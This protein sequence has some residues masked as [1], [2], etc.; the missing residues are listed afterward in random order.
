MEA[1]TTSRPEGFSEGIRMSAQSSNNAVSESV[2]HQQFLL[3]VAARLVVLSNLISAHRRAE[4]EFFPLQWLV[5]CLSKEGGMRIRKTRTNLGP[6]FISTD[7]LNTLL[8]E[9]RTSSSHGNPVVIVDEAQLLYTNLCAEGKTYLRCMNAAAAPLNCSKVW[10]GTRVSVNAAMSLYSPVFKSN[11]PV[12]QLLVVGNYR[13]LDPDVVG[14]ILDEIIAPELYST[15]VRAILACALQGRARMLAYFFA[16]LLPAD[17]QLPVPTDSNSFDN[18]LLATLERTYVRAQDDFSAEIRHFTTIPHNGGLN[19]Q[20]DLDSLWLRLSLNQAEE[21][22]RR[23]QQRRTYIDAKCRDD[24]LV[25]VEGVVAQQPVRNLGDTQ[26]VTINVNFI[27]RYGEQGLLE[28]V[29]RIILNAPNRKIRVQGVVT[30]L[31]KRVT[32]DRSALGSVFDYALALSLLMCGPSFLSTYCIDP[33]YETYKLNYT[34]SLRRVVAVST[35][36]EQLEFLHRAMRDPDDVEF[37]LMPGIPV[38]HIAI[39][40]HKRSGADLLFMATRKSTIEEPSSPG[41]ESKNWVFRTRKRK[42]DA[43]ANVVALHSAV[44]PTVLV[45]V[46]ATVTETPSAE[47]IVDQERKSMYQFVHSGGMR[48]TE[49]EEYINVQE[50]ALSDRKLVYLP[51]VF[52]VTRS[53]KK[54]ASPGINCIT[55]ETALQG[56]LFSTEAMELLTAL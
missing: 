43:E 33:Q 29:Q 32:F 37:S 56:E 9:V 55:A 35:V 54:L 28:A 50:R 53:A 25:F 3:E 38:K 14:S 51:H 23:T 18:L 10:C 44:S 7:W 21:V 22:H 19:D 8:E 34:V 39:L 41:T 12:V 45:H 40:P 2:I 5:F 52:E 36:Q 42:A 1:P 16:L 48:S 11:D 20:R 26:S 4:V 30:D 46:C 24:S 49:E 6:C 13:Y 15:K 31:L 27:P 17:K 47:K